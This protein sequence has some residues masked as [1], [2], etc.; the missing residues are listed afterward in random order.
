MKRT[1]IPTD[2]IE[3]ELVARVKE[4]RTRIA[5][6]EARHDDGPVYWKSLG[7]LDETIRVASIL[8]FRESVVGATATRR[9]RVKD[10]P[11][12]LASEHLHMPAHDASENCQSGRHTHCSCNVCF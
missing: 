12:C 10:C 1:A 8:G 2:E 3:A 5:S 6:C 4:L 7:R 11:T 9:G